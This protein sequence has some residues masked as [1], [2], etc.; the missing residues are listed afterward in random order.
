MN[1]ISVYPVSEFMFIYT[2]FELGVASV[3]DS[4]QREGPLDKEPVDF[5]ICKNLRTY[6]LSWSIRK[7]STCIIQGLTRVI[8]GGSLFGE[9]RP[10]LMLR[11][12]LKAV[13]LDFSPDPFMFAVD[14]LRAFCSPLLQDAGT[15][16][17]LHVWVF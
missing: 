8:C 2:F 6:I 5:S 4:S 16:I 10:L 12:T 7:T 11:E 15:C 9:F 14:S 17:G 13:A 3:V 1:K